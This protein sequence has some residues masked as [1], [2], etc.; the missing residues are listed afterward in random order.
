[1]SVD[2]DARLD[3]LIEGTPWWLRWPAK[4]AQVV[5]VLW[6]AFWL[7]GNVMDNELV[8]LLGAGLLFFAVRRLA[9][10]LAQGA[11]R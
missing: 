1:M 2:E 10:R 9:F 6:L 5:V 4:I 7:Y 3:Q 8:A 11:K